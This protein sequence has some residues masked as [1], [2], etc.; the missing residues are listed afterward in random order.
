MI[1]SP[2]SA[3]QLVHLLEAKCHEVLELT[4]PGPLEHRRGLLWNQEQ[5][6]HGVQLV[7]RRLAI[8]HLH[9]CGFSLLH[10]RDGM[11][12][13]SACHAACHLYACNAIL[14][15]PAYLHRA[16]QSSAQHASAGSKERLL[17][18]IHA[19]PCHAQGVSVDICI[20]NGA[21]AASASSTKAA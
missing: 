12:K 9:S 2:M 13:G 3:G 6:A 10:H 1:A 16:A 11:C 4:A 7:H 8:R 17:R 5:H 18:A 21:S 20:S 19:A 15:Q 14:L